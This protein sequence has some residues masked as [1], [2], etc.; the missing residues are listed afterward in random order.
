MSYLC[1]RLG[2]GNYMAGLRTG[3]RRAR[4]IYLLEEP[5]DQEEYHVV[6]NGVDSA[7]I[8]ASLSERFRE[9][10]LI[11]YWSTQAALFQ[12]I[13]EKLKV[14]NSFAIIAKGQL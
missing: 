4:G 5:S 2:R 6:R 3:L 14:V 8:V 10:K 7:A 11:R 12:R 9:L 1:W 13:G